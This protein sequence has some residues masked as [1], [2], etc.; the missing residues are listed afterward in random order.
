VCWQSPVFIDAL[1]FLLNV[2]PHLT[3]EN[4][5]SS[6]AHTDQ[7]SY[8]IHTFTY[9]MNMRRRRRHCHHLAIQPIVQSVFSQYYHHPKRRTTIHV[10][11]YTPR[12]SRDYHI[13]LLHLCHRWVRPY[14]TTRYV[15][16][17]VHSQ[18]SRAR[19]RIDC[20]FQS[21]IISF[22]VVACTSSTI[23]SQLFSYQYHQS[24]LQQIEESSF[25]GLRLAYTDIHTVIGAYTF[26]SAIC[27]KCATVWYNY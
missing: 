19:N 7:H 16:Q 25:P 26:L 14:L 9:I 20:I 2:V 23:S 22:T 21:H 24:T 17:I 18:E 13:L 8:C 4:T 10:D 12:D 27:Y 5:P 6:M 15:I 3:R 1:L 11:A